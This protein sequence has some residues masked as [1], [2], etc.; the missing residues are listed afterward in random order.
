M[1]VENLSLSQPLRESLGMLC[2][3][4]P[5]NRPVWNRPWQ[6]SVCADGCAVN[7]FFFDSF[8]FHF[9]QISRTIRPCRSVAF[10]ED[11]HDCEYECSV[12]MV[13]FWLHIASNCCQT[14]RDHLMELQCA[15]SARVHDQ[16]RRTT[17]ALRSSVRHPSSLEAG[18]WVRRV[19]NRY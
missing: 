1:F 7:V 16:A 18:D 4:F 13:Y 19:G 2:L 14:V 11:E 8:T 12:C 6:S 9:L 5:A 15:C 3:I 17:R 10:L